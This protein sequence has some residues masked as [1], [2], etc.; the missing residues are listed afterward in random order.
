MDFDFSGLEFRQLVAP[1]SGIASKSL[2]ATTSESE[3]S[4]A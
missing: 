1:R 3:N 4:H 2:A